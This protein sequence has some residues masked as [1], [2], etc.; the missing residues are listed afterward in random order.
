MSTPK[1]LP[2]D[3]ARCHDALCPFR[4]DCLRF[5]R[6]GDEGPSIA[7][8]QTMGRWIAGPEQRVWSCALHIS[9][10]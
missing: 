9:A 7:H 10:S 1:T 8:V 6:R 5:L 2:N 3:R 4:E